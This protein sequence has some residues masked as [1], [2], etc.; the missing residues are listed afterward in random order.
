[1]E[2]R[3]DAL[4]SRAILED[5][6]IGETPEL[7]RIV[8]AVDPPA[9][10]RK[11]SDACGIVAAGLDKEGN[12]VV[13]A[14]ATVRAAKPQDWAGAAVSLFHRIQADCLVA[15]VNQGGDMV[16]A[17]IRTVDPAVPVKAVRSQRGKWTARRARGRTLPA[18]QGAA[19]RPLCR[20]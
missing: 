9:S 13:L 3:E 14:D 5:C 18:G 16:T 1:M 8:V 17:V 20:T 15:E 6:L 19:R 2:D 4:W 7:G 12:A 11:T 10:S